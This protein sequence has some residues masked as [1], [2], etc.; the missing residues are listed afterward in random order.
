MEWTRRRRR[1]RNK[2]N[3]GEKGQPIA[4]K[5]MKLCRLTKHSHPAWKFS[6]CIFHSHSLLCSGT[7]FLIYTLV[8]ISSFY[9]IFFGWKDWGWASEKATRRLV[10]NNDNHSGAESWKTLPNIWVMLQSR[11]NLPIN[12]LLLRLKRLSVLYTVDV[13]IYLGRFNH[14]PLFCDFD[15]FE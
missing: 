13:D 9:V 2:T 1:R 11:L 4:M 14:R 5:W 7:C 10:T 3:Y 8:T 15:I 12:G 6:S